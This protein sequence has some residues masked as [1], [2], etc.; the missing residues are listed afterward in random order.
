MKLNGFVGT[1]RG[2]LG[3]SVFSTVAGQQIVRQYQPAVANPNTVAQVTQRARLKL[4]SQL[5]AAM[6]SVIA[7]PRDGL[8]SSR[9]LFI[10]RN[11][12][13]IVGTNAGAQISY[14]NIQLTTGNTG[15][16]AIQILRSE[17]AGITVQLLEDASVAVSRVVYI[18]FK[19]TTEEQMQLVGSTVISEAGDLGTFP[20][21]FPYLDGELIAYAYGLK[22]FS[23]S[24][25]AKY[26][27]YA[28][29][30]GEDIAAL[31]LSRRLNSSDFGFT[32]TRGATIFDGSAE[33]DSAGAGRYMVYITATE[34][35]S[36]S[37]DGF[38]N[39][40]KAVETGTSVTVVA[41]AD[42]GYDFDGWRANGQT[43]GYLSRSNSYTFEVNSLT[44]LVAVFSREETPGGGGAG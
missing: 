31:V 18:L 3:S 30:N 8:R 17:T 24:A 27:D 44:D 4:A 41:T 13:S 5:A 23:A 1:G 40:R 35:G 32:Q 2:K 14:E 26:G 16:P 39:G 12:D 28:V 21:S 7:I 9:N 29:A 37:G 42:E 22:D 38:V 10:S 34:G 15:L 6:A 11:F 43:S 33:S 36:V 25:T 19:K 20:A